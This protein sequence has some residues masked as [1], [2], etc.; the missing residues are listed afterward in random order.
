LRQEK[1]KHMAAQTRS[2]PRLA[3]SEL[4]NNAAERASRY[5]AEIGERR[6]APSATDLAALA[7][8]HE[9]FPEKPTDPREV[10]RMLD[11]IGSPCTVATTGRR[12]FGFVIGGALPAAMAASW[13]ANAW[14]QNACLRVMSPI[15]AEL[16]EIVFRWIYDALGLPADCAGGL[17]TCATSANFTALVAARHA[18][19]ARQNWNI[20]DDGMFGAPPIDVVVA[21]EAHAS[22]LKALALA[23]FGKKRVCIVETDG[24]GRMRADK[25]PTLNDRTIVCIQAGNVNTGAFDPAKEIC[26]RGGEAGAWVHVDGAFGLWAG[27]SQKYKHLLEGFEQADSWATDAHKW[28]NVSYD[29]GI[30]IVRDGAALRAAM[31]VDAAYLQAGALREPMHFVPEASRRARGVEL[32]AALKSL[33]RSGLC[34]IIERTCLLAQR[35]AEGL[36]AAGFNV[37]NDVVINQVLVSFG[38]A[39]VTRQVIR[40]LQEDGTCWCGAT[41][42]QGHTAMRISVSSAMTTEADVDAS[43]DAMVRI[44]SQCKDASAH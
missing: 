22:V 24:Q 8:F 33:G 6:V 28:P 4:L 25:L 12:Y 39:A 43:L 27:V 30:V 2:E 10:L 18:L 19:L 1:V 40:E 21:A 38:D 13:L 20:A 26:R 36:R 34:A 11:Q 15:A 29:S 37:L 17:V 14:D 42:W 44:A 23:G 41:E 3:I 32:W 35:F 5:V 9:T 7:H 16:E 31:A